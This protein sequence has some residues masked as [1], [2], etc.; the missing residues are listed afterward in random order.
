MFL[1]LLFKK[2][3][4]TRATGQITL[5]G[6]SV[7]GKPTQATAKITGTLQPLTGRRCRGSLHKLQLKLRAPLTGCSCRGGLYEL[8]D[9]LRAPFA[10]RKNQMV[11]HYL[12]AGGWL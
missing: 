10:G 11:G 2:A 7:Q 9:K 12:L 1:Y 3:K 4:R 8:Q 6:S 5:D